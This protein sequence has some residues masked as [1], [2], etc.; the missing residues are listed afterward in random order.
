LTNNK[1]VYKDFFL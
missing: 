1:R